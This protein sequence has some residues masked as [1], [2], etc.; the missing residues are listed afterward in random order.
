MF[1]DA[2]TSGEN[3]AEGADASFA[4]ASFADASSSSETAATSGRS[5]P[6]LSFSSPG[7]SEGFSGISP[8]LAAAA[9]AA[10]EAMLLPLAASPPSAAA[11]AARD[12]VPGG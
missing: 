7:G 5:S 3:A 11:A 6:F 2:S 12:V 8:R 10:S 4:N 9:A 1:P